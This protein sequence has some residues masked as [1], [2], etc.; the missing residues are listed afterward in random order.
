VDGVVV[1]TEEPRW[2]EVE[3]KQDMRNRKCCFA[4]VYLAICDSKLRFMWVASGCTGNTNDSLAWEQTSLSKSL[5]K[6]P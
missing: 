2:G 6:N 3:N 5:E 4:M 1:A